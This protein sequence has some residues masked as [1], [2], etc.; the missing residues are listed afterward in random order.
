MP[1][2]RALVVFSGGQDSTIC[3]FWAKYIQKYEEIRGITFDYGQRHLREVESAEIVWEM[4]GLNSRDLEVVRVGGNVLKSTSPLVNRNFLLE[5]YDSYEKMQSVIGDRV[6][7]TFVPMRNALFLTIAANRAVAMDCNIVIGVCQADGAN[8]P[9]CRDVF[10]KRMEQMFEQSL[11]GNFPLIVTPL[12]YMK[13]SE[14][15]KL[16]LGIPRCYEALAYS[17]TAYDGTF[18]PTG[19]DH[20]SVLR[21]Y[22]FE[23]AGV[24]DPLILRSAFF[25]NRP[26]PN[27]LNYKYAAREM[28]KYKTLNEFLSAMEE[29]YRIKQVE[30]D[31][32]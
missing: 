11:G 2:N 22:G 12:L 14:S 28:G 16:A 27:T 24:P 21:A 32:E 6:E 3:L 8:Y 15:V 29:Y 26:L 18:P 20:A 10:I 31:K 30:L 5:T 1:I 7:L 9:D 17:H 25:Y 19:N 13:K 23:E 4:A